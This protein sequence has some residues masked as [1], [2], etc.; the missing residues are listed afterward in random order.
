MQTQVEAQGWQNKVEATWKK[1]SINDVLEPLQSS[2]LVRKLKW[3]PESPRFKQACQNLQIAS[4]EIELKTKK[5]F[6]DEIKHEQK[7]QSGPDMTSE[8]SAIRYNYHLQSVKDFLNDIIHERQRIIIKQK[9]NGSQ[10]A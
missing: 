4:H 7:K 6:E 5:Q 9:I 8:L 3:D 1:T 2:R 10:Q